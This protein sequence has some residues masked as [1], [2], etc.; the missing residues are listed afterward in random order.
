MFEE[1]ISFEEIGIEE[2]Y[3]LEI[4]SE[5]HNFYANDICVS[6]S[7]ALSYSYLAMQT[8]FLK[9]YYPTEF[10]TALLNH[11]KDS[12]KKEEQQAWISTAISSAI[13]KGIKVV[14]PTTKTGWNWTMT[15]DK[16][17]SMG[18]G[19]INGFGEIAYAELNRLLTEKNKTLDT[20][21][22]GQFFDLPFSK[23]NKKAFESAV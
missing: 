1:I 13:A 5:F 17:I 6:N 23:F 2:T 15:G 20:I 21:T 18:F 4:D 12:G 11:P 7:H 9:H 19:G 10:Y 22:I 14:P 3:D 16:E 8:L